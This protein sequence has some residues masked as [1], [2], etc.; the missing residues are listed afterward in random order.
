M[1]PIANV[2]MV[3]DRI[4]GLVFGIITTAQQLR[5]EDRLLSHCMHVEQCGQGF[6]DC[7]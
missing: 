7:A 3:A 2:V 6:P 5:V 1:Y 4:D